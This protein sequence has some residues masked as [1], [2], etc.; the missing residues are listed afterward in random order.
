MF[1][2]NVFNTTISVVATVAATAIIKWLYLGTVNSLPA[3]YDLSIF[4]TWKIVARG[5]KI[6]AIRYPI[7][8]ELGK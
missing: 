4:F 2:D 7:T 1:A 3:S 8:E 6:Q 5:K